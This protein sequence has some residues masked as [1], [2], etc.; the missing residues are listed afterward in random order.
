MLNYL[1]NL[2]NNVVPIIGIEQISENN[3]NIQFVDPSNVNNGLLDEINGIINSWPLNQSKILKIKDLDNYWNFVIQNGFTTSYGWKLG[4]QNNDITL[5]TGAFLMAKEASNMNISQD[6]TIVDLQG[7]SHILSIND[8]TILMLEYGQYRTQLS[9]EY[10]NKK[11]LI[12]SAQTIE[13][14]NNI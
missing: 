11:N 7:V 8:F 2:I 5:L 6:V 12:N 4:L 10:S 13:E 3:F 9:A 14:V 1:H